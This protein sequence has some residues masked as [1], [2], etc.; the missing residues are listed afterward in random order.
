MIK[1]EMS[2][3]GP[4]ALP[5]EYLPLMKEQQKL[6]HRVRPGITG[7]A[8]VSGRHGISWKEKF[9]L[10]EQYIC[11]LSFRLDVGILFKTFLLLLNPKED[12]SLEEK[13]FE[14]NS[15]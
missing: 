1:G 15:S 14:G 6:R 10:D 3:V 7:L 8:Q 13:K 2:L 9:T 12:C 5:V 4:R 11:T